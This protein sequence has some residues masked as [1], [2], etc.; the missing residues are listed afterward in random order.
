MYL[1][2]TFTLIVAYKAL[3]FLD[4]TVMTAFP[5]F[6]ALI[7]PEEEIVATF[8]LLDTN[9]KF[10]N[11]VLFNFM[12]FLILAFFVYLYSLVNCN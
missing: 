11:F 3:L 8:V 12:S 1:F 4:F 5:A 10:F 2:F 6:F 9:V 7:F